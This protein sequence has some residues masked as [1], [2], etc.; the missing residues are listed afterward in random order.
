MYEVWLL[1][2][3]STRAEGVL[4]GQ[5]AKRMQ[6][7]IAGSVYYSST[8]TCGRC[9]STFY[10]EVRNERVFFLVPITM[11]DE[12][13]ELISSPY[14]YMG[15]VASMRGESANIQVLTR[16]LTRLLMINLYRKSTTTAIKIGFRT[17]IVDTS[18]YP[19]LHLFP[20]LTL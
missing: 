14:R 17:G 3:E 19:T 16:V 1:C 20:T 18:S 8:K 2:N 13:H 15:Q 6:R 12:N 7:W 9:G 10:I 11:C 5:D 4:E